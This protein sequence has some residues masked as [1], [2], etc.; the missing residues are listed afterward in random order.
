[1]SF[2]SAYTEDVFLHWTTKCCWSNPVTG[3]LLAERTWLCLQILWYFK[4]LELSLC[5]SLQHLPYAYLLNLVVGCNGCLC[6]L[7]AFFVFLPGQKHQL[8]D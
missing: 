8:N 1:M 2:P 6:G 3:V 4:R 7:F 5:Y